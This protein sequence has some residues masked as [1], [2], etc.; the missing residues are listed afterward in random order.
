MA[1]LQM[2][3]QNILYQ[4]MVRE[5]YVQSESERYQDS[6]IDNVQ[7]FKMASKM[8]AAILPVLYSL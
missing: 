2:Y 8:A 1:T 6:L 7:L 4:I 3:S 5:V